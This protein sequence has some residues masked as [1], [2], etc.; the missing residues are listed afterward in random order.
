MEDSFYSASHW[1]F[2]EVYSSNSE[3]SEKQS[4]NDSDCNRD[5]KKKHRRVEKPTKKASSKDRKRKDGKKKREKRHK[6]HKKR[7]H[8]GEPSAEDRAKAFDLL[9]R[10]GD[11]S[12]AELAK[13]LR[14]VVR[15]TARSDMAHDSRAAS[16]IL[17]ASFHFAACAGDLDGVQLLLQEGGAPVDWRSPAGDTNGLTAL[18]VACLLC[19][20]PL[21][22]LLVKHG[23]DCDLET[24]SGESAKDMGLDGLLID[25]ANE[26]AAWEAKKRAV[27]REKREAQELAREVRESKERC[28]VRSFFCLSAIALRFQEITS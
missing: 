19:D 18:H 25:Y 10:G 13:Q 17:G 24:S 5:S 9:L 8:K 21:A 3:S 7:R 15:A 16:D 26:V 20:G 28:T 23:A 6:K 12:L 11:C 22:T 1:G 4:S 14:R 27:E 2:D